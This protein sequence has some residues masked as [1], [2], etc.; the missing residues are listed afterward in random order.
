[1]SCTAEGVAYFDSAIV[2]TCGPNVP[3]CKLLLEG[4][5]PG[6]PFIYAFLYQRKVPGQAWTNEYFY[7]PQSQ[8]PAPAVDAAT[9]RDQ[10]IKLLPRVGIGTTGP[11]PSSL[12][13]IQ[14]LLW[15]QTSA[16]R[17]L[18]RV[19][20]LGQPV[21]LRLAF[22]Q[23]DWDFGDGHTATAGTPGK[24]YDDAHDP[25][26][27]TLCPHYYGHV[28][29]QAGP[30]TITLRVRWHASYSLD[31]RTFQ[32]VEGGPVTGPAAHTALRIKQARVVLVPNPGD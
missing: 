9:I 13:N 28:Y 3:V 2:G 5:Q 14:T 20:L 30:V 19:E 11:E 7:C 15:A 6:H 22:E 1:M 27:A 17:D 4:G 32:P 16:D 10:V 25:C 18:G 23:A 24:A 21:W 8:A 26:A 12:V 29:R 31:G